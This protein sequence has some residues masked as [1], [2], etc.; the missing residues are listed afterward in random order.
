MV[1]WV[2]LLF[3]FHYNSIHYLSQ[4]L[5]AGTF[6]FLKKRSFCLLVCVIWM[7]FLSKDLHMQ[8]CIFIYYRMTWF[9]H[10]IGGYRWLSGIPRLLRE[11][12]LIRLRSLMVEGRIVTWLHLAGHALLCLMVL[13][14]FFLN[15]NL[16]SSFTTLLSFFHC[17]AMRLNV[18]SKFW[19][20]C[21]HVGYLNWLSFLSLPL[22]SL[23]L[24]L[25][26]LFII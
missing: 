2:S 5:L 13:H 9:L 25:L 12:V 4:S 19:I 7:C 24:S 18:H 10:G 11:P 21:R 23:L 14:T 17:Y 3:H 26:L 8:V 20:W 22:S 1:L 15:L 16:L 6:F